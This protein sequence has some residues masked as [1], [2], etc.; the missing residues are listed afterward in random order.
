MNILG[1][2]SRLLLVLGT[3]EAA[4]AE[5]AVALVGL[6]LH[7]RRHVALR[8]EKVVHLHVVVDKLVE[9]VSGVGRVVLRHVGT[10]RRS[11]AA[12]LERA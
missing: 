6:E 8:V 11:A 4:G 9:D 7:D 2:D 10:R 5:G 1:V 3:V 12:L